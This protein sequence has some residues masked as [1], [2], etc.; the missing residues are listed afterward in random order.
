ME[1]IAEIENC[2]IEVMDEEDVYNSGNVRHVLV[3]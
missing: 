2:W 3:L 1:S